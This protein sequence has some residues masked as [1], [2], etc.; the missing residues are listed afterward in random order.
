MGLVYLILIV[1]FLDLPFRV[2]PIRVDLDSVPGRS[3]I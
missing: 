3:L 1:L 2:G